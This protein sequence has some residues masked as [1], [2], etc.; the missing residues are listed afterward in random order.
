M[1]RYLDRHPLAAH[2]PA[3]SSLPEAWPSC[4]LGKHRLCHRRRVGSQVREMP[5]FH[6]IPTVSFVQKRIG[7]YCPWASKNYM[8]QGSSARWYF[9]NSVHG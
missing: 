4:Q 7:Q 6:G 3:G 5:F 8:R 9:P 2:E 1:G